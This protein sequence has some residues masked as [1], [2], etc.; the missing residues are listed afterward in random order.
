VINR[1]DKTKHP[2]LRFEASNDKL[3]VASKPEVSQQRLTYI[4]QKYSTNNVKQIK[5]KQQKKNTKKSYG[6]AKKTTYNTSIKDRL[7]NVFKQVKEWVTKGL[8]KFAIYMIG[9][10]FMFVVASVLILTMLQSFSGAVSTVVSTSYQ[11]SDLVVT[12]SDALSTHVET[13]V[14]LNN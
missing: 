4:K 3:N 8:K 12:N 5:N 10:I 7:K 14:K 11:S 2:K 13:V 6:K 1:A 9:P